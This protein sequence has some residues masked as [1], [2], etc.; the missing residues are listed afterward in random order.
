MFDTQNPNRVFEIYQTPSVGYTQDSNGFSA[1]IFKHRQTSKLTVSF[2]GTEPKFPEIQDFLTDISALLGNPGGFL[3]LF[4][5]TTNIDDFLESNNLLSDGQLT[6]A[7]NFTGHSLGGY[8]SLMAA[9]KY[10][11]SFG[12]ANTYNSL[13]LNPIES[14][15]EQISNVFEGRQL[16]ET[17]V[18]NYFADK[19]FEGAANPLLSR[20]GGMQELFIEYDGLIDDLTFTNHGI[21][22]LVE[23]LSLYRVLATLDSK[24]DSDDGLKKIYSILDASSNDPEQSLENIVV[25]LG[26]LLGGDFPANTGDIELFYQ[27]LF[28]E[29]ALK[30]EYQNL[31]IK[32]SSIAQDDIGYRYAL[33]HLN[34][35]TITGF[36]YSSHNN[37]H[38]L[39]LYNPETGEGTLT[40]P[41]D[42]L[43]RLSHIS[44]EIA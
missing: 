15:W 17:K 29:G 40:A 11:S 14:I 30:P 5:Q 43:H 31:T 13:G 22:K 9:Y 36:D 25:K 34:P 37:N 42:L 19:G 39:D 12:E 2:R 32:S 44:K 3:G 28:N 16:D 35:F 38:Q 1:T 23:S 4:D 24:L 10:S 8:L 6:Q 26:A 18:H 33:L 41:S 27:L 21:N 7:V 20:P